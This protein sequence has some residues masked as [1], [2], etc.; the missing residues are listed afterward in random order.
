M[1]WQIFSGNIWHVVVLVL[2][3]P[4]CYLN[5]RSFTAKRKEKYIS[6]TGLSGKER[7][8]L[9]RDCKNDRRKVFFGYCLWILCVIFAYGGDLLGLVLSVVFTLGALCYIYSEALAAKDD[10]LR[11]YALISLAVPFVIFALITGIKYLGIFWGIIIGI[12]L[13]VGVYL[14][15]KTK[16]SKHGKITKKIRKYFKDLLKE[17]DEE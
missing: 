11:I 6:A 8:D 3:T 7:T 10:N 9:L 15:G 13:A 14:L 1:N 2:A 12:A 16:S 17:D 5:W 4:F